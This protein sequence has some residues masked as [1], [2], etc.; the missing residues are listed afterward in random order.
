MSR[1]ESKHH[2]DRVIMVDW[3]A[4]S[5]P[6]RGRDSIWIAVGSPA[7]G[8]EHLV[9]PPTR[10]AAMAWLVDLLGTTRH[11]RV[12]VGF[13]FSFGYPAGF[14]AAL[15]GRSEA[16]WADVWR[17]MA[18]HLT[19]DDQ[20]RNNRLDAMAQ[21]N[22]QLQAAVGTAPFWGYPGRARNDALGRTKPPS[23]APFD[24]FRLTEHRVRTRGYRPFSAWQLA[25]NGSVGSQML[26]GLR[27]LQGLRTHALLAGRTRVWPFETGLGAASIELA[28]GQVLVA[29]IWPSL[30]QFDSTAHPVRDAAQ[31]LSMV[32]HLITL[33]AEGALTPWFDPALSGRELV[34]VLGEEG[35]TAG[36]S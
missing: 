28:P 33:D 24:Q 19:D 15:T 17:W 34:T 5:S 22:A 25:Y 8:V 2:F 36:V 23:Y 31:V 29:E 6:K 11:E 20:N 16:D 10:S 12:L 3:S 35:W 1:P 21:V 26:L 32:R 18:Q 30:I 7:Q 27:S 4:N 13:D 14:A 9:N